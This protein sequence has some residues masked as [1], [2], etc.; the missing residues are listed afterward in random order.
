MRF[1]YFSH[2]RK[3]FLDTN[4]QLSSGSRGLNCGL[5]IHLHIVSVCT[6]SVGYGE[7]ERLGV[8]YG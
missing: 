4:A 2:M 3:L 8:G 6:N 7:T 1:R 5:S